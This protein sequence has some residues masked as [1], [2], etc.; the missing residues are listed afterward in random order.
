MASSAHILVGD[1]GGTN[2]RLKLFLVSPSDKV[3]ANGNAP[4]KLIKH[5]EYANAQHSAFVDIVRA[6][7][8]AEPKTEK[9][10]IACCLAV[11]GPVES[12]RVSF[13]NRESWGVIDGERLQASLGIKRVRLIN[14]FVAN[15]YGLLTLNHDKECVCLQDAPK[16]AG[17][18]IAC[19]G[20]GTGL[21]ECYSTAADPSLPYE[22]FASEGGHADWAPR[23]EVETEL[24][25]H[26]K[27]KFGQKH[28]VSVER[29]ISGPGLANVYEFLAAKYPKKVNR[30]VQAEF[31]SAGDM[32]GKVVATHAPSGA[33]PHCA[34]CA[35][36]MGIFLGAYGAEVGAAA[37][38]FLPLGGMYVAGGLTPKNIG[39]IRAADGA[40]MDAFYDKGRLS[41]VM[42]RVPLYAVMVEDIGQRGAH[43]VAYKLLQQEPLL[44]SN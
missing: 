41:P 38:K 7:L 24:H 28:R 13:T 11:A 17:A 26:L 10:P 40:F 35:Q 33:S 30:Q 39:P 36:A 20:A 18:P 1:I 44:S 25:S 12:N 27:A 32:Q 34:L 2:T 22:T 4:G 21:G 8:A 37:L 31:D 3:D 23:D 15:G 19:V 16:I 42:R 43:L 29:V 5:L 6:F 9:P 14:D